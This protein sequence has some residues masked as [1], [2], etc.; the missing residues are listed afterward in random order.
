MDS[1]PVGFDAWWNRPN[2]PHIAIAFIDLDK[3]AFEAIWKAA[4]DALRADLAASTQQ[5]ISHS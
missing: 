3:P 4:Q 1:K 2:R 5:K